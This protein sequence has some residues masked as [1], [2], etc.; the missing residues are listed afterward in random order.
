M[1]LGGD[2]TISSMRREKQILLIFAVFPQ[3]ETSLLSYTPCEDPVRHLSLSL[4]LPQ[5]FSVLLPQPLQL[6]R[7]RGGGGGGPE[8]WTRH[9]SRV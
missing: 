8:P 9:L 4:Q 5:E 2:G 1:V 3:F 7:I 6:R